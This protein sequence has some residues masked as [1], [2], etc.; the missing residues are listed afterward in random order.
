[1]ETTSDGALTFQHLFWSIWKRLGYRL[2]DPQER[3]CYAF[4]LCSNK[5][6]NIVYHEVEA[7]LLCGV[8]KLVD[9]MQE[10]PVEEL[11]KKHNW[12]QA[13]LVGSGKSTAKDWH[14]ATRKNSPLVVEGY[15]VVDSNWRR[16]LIQSK[17]FQ[18]LEHLK[19]LG[20]GARETKMSLFEVMTMTQDGGKEL[21]DRFPFANLLSPYQE[22]KSKFDSLCA[23]VEEWI[24]ATNPKS[25]QEMRN[26]PHIQMEEKFWVTRFKGVHKNILELFVYYQKSKGMQKHMTQWAKTHL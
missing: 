1:M 10:V 2:P 25:A 19:G 23:S 17:L 3:L 15:V 4:E 11:S 21:L 7:L 13:K 20:V 9:D 12:Q 24:A 18:E 22:V 14:L 5:C 6:R 16:V 8:R 26:C